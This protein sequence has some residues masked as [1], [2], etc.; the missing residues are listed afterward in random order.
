MS[1]IVVKMSRCGYQGTRKDPVIGQQRWGGREVDTDTATVL[2]QTQT[3]TSAESFTAPKLDTGC[4]AS[5]RTR[6]CR[7]H[8][9]ACRDCN[10]QYVN[11]GDVPRVPIP[12]APAIHARHVGR[13]RRCLTCLMQLPPRSRLTPVIEC[14]S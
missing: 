2:T 9:C 10:T 13:N 7:A 5:M 6:G 14:L 11:F 12:T 1:K 4:N 8:A 3:Q